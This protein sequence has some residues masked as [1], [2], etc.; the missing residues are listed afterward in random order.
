LSDLL[1]VETP[2][3]EATV[4]VAA[5][6]ASL[7]RPGD[8]L[9]LSGDLGAGKTTFT[10][11][12]VRGLGSPAAVSS[13]TFT[14]IHE[15]AGGRLNV[16][17]MDAY[18]LTGA[19]E[20]DAI[21]FD[22]YLTQEDSVLVIEWPERIASAVPAERLEIRLQETAEEGRRLTFTGHGD[23]WTEAWQTLGE[24]LTPC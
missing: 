5:R 3:E 21:G 17:H 19:A 24:N 14:L 11:G 6:L 13:P 10:R 23:R 22:D 2:D 15:Y 1:V 7:L 16:V 8:V 4:A 18:R 20:L 9:C 12:L